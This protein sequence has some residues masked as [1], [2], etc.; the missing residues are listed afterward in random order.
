MDARVKY[1]ILPVAQRLMRADQAARVSGEGYLIG[2]VLHEISHGLGPAF[3]RAGGKQMDIRESIGPVYSALEEAKA[4][5]VGMF[6][7]P[8]LAR[9]GALAKDRLPEYYASY[10]AGLLRSLR[11]G[12]G[13]AHGRAELM[14]FNYLRQQRAISHTGGRYAVEM[15]R[16][17]PALAALAKRLLEIE[18]TGDRAGAEAWFAKYGN[19]EP[20]LQRALESA[21]DVPVDLDPVFSYKEDVR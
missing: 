4:D 12:T 9:R 17:E 3:A 19:M 2:T 20:E 11:F 21:R 16:I 5:V 15:A 7:I 10:A 18:A 1:V 13:E 14:E 6:G 8:L